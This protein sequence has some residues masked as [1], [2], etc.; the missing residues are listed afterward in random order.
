MEDELFGLMLLVPRNYHML[1]PVHK[2]F[3]FIKDELQASRCHGNGRRAI[4]QADTLPLL[5]RVQ[6]SL[7]MW[8]GFAAAHSLNYY[9]TLAKKELQKG[10]NRGHRIRSRNDS[11]PANRR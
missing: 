4:K 3:L 11:F 5:P 2:I 1:E 6:V 8:V 10:A 9:L 7:D